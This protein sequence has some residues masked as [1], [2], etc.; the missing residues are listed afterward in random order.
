[1][2]GIELNATKSPTEF[3]LNNTIIGR[4]RKLALSLCGGIQSVKL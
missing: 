2:Q 1:M 3:V 4:A